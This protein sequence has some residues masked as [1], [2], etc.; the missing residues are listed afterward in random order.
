VKRGALLLVLGA[1]VV[2]APAARTAPPALPKPSFEYDGALRGFAAAGFRV[3]V[4]DWCDVM[5][6]RLAAGAKTTLQHVKSRGLS[7]EDPDLDGE[8]YIDGLWLGRRSFAAEIICCASSIHTNGYELWKGPL[9]SGRA[10][11]LASWSEDTIEETAEGCVGVVATGG[12]VIAWTE[13]PN[14]YNPNKP[15]CLSK[16]TTTIHLDGAARAR[17]TVDGSWT[18][19][20]TDGKRVVLKRLDED[21]APTS[22]LMV[23]GLDGKRLATPRVSA[24]DVEA[25]DSG[26]LVPEGLV[27]DRRTSIVGP[28]WKLNKVYSSKT[29]VGYGRV[30]YLR[31]SSL[32]AR[33]IRDGADRLVLTLPKRG[34]KYLA[35]GS[36]G[37]AIGIQTQ[38]SDEEYRTSV[39][40]IGWK[41]IDAALPAR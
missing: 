22:E 34:D 10:H 15:T 12:G 2:A 21:G 11:E 40:R 9:P 6:A 41:V 18:L 5:T 24:A 37:L 26:W 31:G 38:N 33:R 1:I 20:A 39:Y 19:L 4:A 17:T 30:L 32:R 29:T 36:F 27:L 3:A 35:A 8:W 13:I 23:V 7:C 16:G 25:A 28:G 14:T